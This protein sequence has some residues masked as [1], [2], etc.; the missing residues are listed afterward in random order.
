MR[1]L[2]CLLS[3]LGLAACSGAYY[4]AINLGV[5]DDRIGSETYDPTRQLA[6]D[7]H[8]PAPAAVRP[9]IV[10]FLHGGSWRHGT[11]EG[12]RF[13]GQRLAQ[14]G[15]LALVPDYRKAPGH[16]FPDFMY[17]TARAVAW[18]KANGERLGGD[19]QRVFVMGHSAGAH[20][21]ALLATDPR[22]LADVGLAPRDLAGVVALAGPYDFLPL[23]DPELFEVFGEREQ[24]PLSQ[25]VNFA[26]GDEPPFLLLHGKN[27]RIVWAL[28]SERLKA[29]LDAGGSPARY[30]PIDGTG[31]I[32]ILLSLR[33]KDPSPALAETLRFLGLDEAGV[34]PPA[35]APAP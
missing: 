11:R 25:P 1:L 24:W 22:Y 21:V 34:S 30:V 3:C 7:I 19:P 31:H 5:Q 26:D 27:D 2:I 14:A 20:I 16:A 9:P 15:A 28:N 10:V 17:D 4:R 33:G 32:G 35:P 8:R 29:K 23:T 6:L 13:V 12:Y 18:A